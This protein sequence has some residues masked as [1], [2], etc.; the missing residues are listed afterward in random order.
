M[1]NKKK[2]KYIESIEVYDNGMEMVK[3]NKPDDI[4]VSPTKFK[5]YCR[6]KNDVV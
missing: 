4:K 6:H 1:I 3:K 5:R 2:I